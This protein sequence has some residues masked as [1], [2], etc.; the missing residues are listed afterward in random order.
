[1]LKS[2]KLHNFKTFL[3]CEVQLSRQ[4]LLIGKNSSGKTNFASALQLLA[5]T[6][7]MTLDQAV[8]VIPGG[9]SEISNWG[10]KSD[11]VEL[12]CTCELEFEGERCEF[13][14]QLNL[15][16]RS[17]TSLSVAERPGLQVRKERL[18]VTCA[19]FDN[20][21][22]LENDGREALLTHEQQVTQ[23]ES[24]HRPR[25]LAPKNATML[26]KLFELETNR[27]AIL[28]RNYLAGWCYFS[29][30]PHAMRYGPVQATQAAVVLEPFGYELSDVIFI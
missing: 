2:L 17:P 22:L 20:V 14:Y 24:P 3:N 8:S 26:S 13:V 27:R 7:G 15:L 18:S 29:L 4:H 19:G 16:Q 12:S 25:T 30:S 11:E 6:S 21:V 9:V 28:F 1:M 10:T 23:S 5:R